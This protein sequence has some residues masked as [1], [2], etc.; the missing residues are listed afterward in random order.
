[1]LANE[2]V[3]KT[4]LMLSH[5]P[6]SVTYS[7][8]PKTQ[9]SLNGIRILIVDDDHNTLLMLSELLSSYDAEVMTAGSV[10]AALVLYRSWM[11]RLL[12]SDLGMP[13]RD[14]YDL[15][16]SIHASL[17]AHRAKR[18]RSRDFRAM[19]IASARSPTV[20]IFSSLNPLNLSSSSI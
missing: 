5:P 1:M 2:G 15:I 19:K 10:T 16:R 14:G 18:S 9:V 7:S 17:K 13:E 6:P 4:S 20:T 12:L 8:E 11:P 3:Y